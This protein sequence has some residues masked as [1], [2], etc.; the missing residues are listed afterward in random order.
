[1]KKIN[2]GGSAI[3]EM[4]KD[5]SPVRDL[6]VAGGQHVVYQLKARGEF[7]AAEV[8]IADGVVNMETGTSVTATTVKI[9]LH[10]PNDL[11]TQM[12]KR[13]YVHIDLMFKDEF[14]PFKQQ[15]HSMGY[16]LQERIAGISLWL[17]Q[18]ESFSVAVE[19][20]NQDLPVINQAFSILVKNTL[21]AW[22]KRGKG[23]GNSQSG[24]NHLHNYRL[25]TPE[26]D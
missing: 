22:K 9:N 3:D 6:K 14:R 15:L 23:T 25:N 13:D 1:M 12:L 2:A 18:L 7:G 11:W 24:E 19:K 21:E 16:V 10:Y 4:L 26:M 5:P 8:E 17:K 20:I